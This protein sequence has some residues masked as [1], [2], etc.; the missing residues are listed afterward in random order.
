DD[1]LGLAVIGRN[2]E[3][4]EWLVWA[5]AWAH[6]SVLE[7]RKAEAARFRDFA[8]DGDLTLV[9]QIGDDVDELASIVARVE[10]AGLLDKVGVDPYG[11]GGILHA[12]EAAGVQKDKV[13]GIPEG[14]KLVGA[15][16]TAERRLAEGGITHGGQ[17][18]MT[19]CVGNAK[20]EP[21][22]NAILITKQASGTAK[23][24]PLI[25]MLNAV[26]L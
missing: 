16:K 17:A 23:I 9:E 14:W 22:G 18:L 11:I 7:R 19:W 25:A 5:H 13:S 24:D 15:I 4:R 6:P 2:S 12:L 26:S 8:R 20:V 1:L 21:R 10:E 3:T